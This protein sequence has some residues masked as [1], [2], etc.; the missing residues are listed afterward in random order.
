MR[1]WR[2]NLKS[3]A[4]TGVNPRE[5]CLKGN[6]VGVGWPVDNKSDTLVWDEYYELAM[7]EYYNRP[8]R[9]NGWWPAVNAMKNRMAI[10]DLIWTRDTKGEYYLGRI[11]SD[12]RYDT[13][14]EC[15]NADIVNIRS[16]EWYKAGTVDKVPGIVVSSFI[17]RAT[18]QS[19]SSSTVLN[20]SKILYNQLSKVSHYEED[21]LKGK[22]IF[23]MIS[24]DDCED[25]VAL[26]L[27]Y[28]QNYLVVPSSCKK[29]TAYYEYVLVHRETGE[30]AVAQVKKGNVSLYA[31]DFNEVDAKV[32]LFTTEGQYEGNFRDNVHILTREKIEAFMNEHFLILPEKIKVW[33]KMTRQETMA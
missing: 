7:D 26:Y 24:D 8:E 33:V 30:S 25:L 2:I 13:S 32:Y 4:K 22:D 19:I 31:S 27:Q 3:A 15:S 28:K 14:S 11:T 17:P 1:I 12:W 29:S 20:Y 16:C 21:S 10:D 9:D 23:S 6:I 18:V 5:F